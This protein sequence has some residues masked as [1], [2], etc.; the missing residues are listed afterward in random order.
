MRNPLSDRR[1]VNFHING[2]NRY[3]LPCRIDQ[4][5]QFCFV[6]R[7][8]PPQFPHLLQRIQTITGLCIGQFDSRLQSEPKVRKLI[9]KGIGR[10]H[11]LFRQITASYNQTTRMATQ[12]L[13]KT[14]NIAGK[15]LT[16]GIDCYRIIKP[17][18]LCFSKPGFQ[19]ISFS[20]V[21]T[22]VDHR[23]IHSGQ[24]GGRTVGTAII[25]YNDVAC[26]PLY[27]RYHLTNGTCIIIC[28]NYH[29]PHDRSS[30]S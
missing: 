10:W 7:R 26:I 11:I 17:Q 18:L 30:T 9:G 21:S 25:Y 14:G 19:R 22:V 23:H 27:I 15:M 8:Q 3:T 1:I 20:P 24:Q 13:Y 12:G 29:A 28:W 16:V 4:R 2:D 6:S 5:L